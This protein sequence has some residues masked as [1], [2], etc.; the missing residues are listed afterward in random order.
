VFTWERLISNA[1]HL[2]HLD[3]IRGKVL[4]F[5]MLATLIPSLTL[6]WQ[7]YGLNKRFITEKI[8]EEVRN[9]TFQVV[10]ELDLW[11]KE[12]LYEI[13]VFSS[14]YEVVENIDRMHTAGPTGRPDDA[15]ARLIQYLQSV[16][17]K[18]GDYEELLVI[19]PSGDVL[20]TSAGQPDAS[21]LPPDWLRQATADSA[22]VGQIYL[23]AVRKRPALK[24]AVP[25][26]TPGGKL[27]GA[28][29]GTLNF[30]TIEKILGRIAFVEGGKAYL[31]REDGAVII[32][33]RPL[34]ALFPQ[35]RLSADAVRG[36]F[37][38]EH[39]TLE[40]ADY[41]GQPVRGTLRRVPHFGWGAVAEV[42]RLEAYAQTNRMWTRT[43]FLVGA[44]LAGISGTAYLL[45]LTI[46]RP[47][48]RLTG[49]AARVSAGDLD[50]QVPVV[51][52]SEVG[53]LT[54]VFNHMVIRLREGRDALAARNRA[55]QE[56]SIT[57]GLTGLYNHKHLL[58]TLDAE[59]ARARRLQHQF[60]VLMLDL[61]HFKRYND[62]Y[63][64]QAGDALLARVSTLFKDSIRSIDYAARYG[65]EEFLLLLHE[66]GLEGALRAAERI[67][68]RVAAERIGPEDQPVQITVSVGVAEFPG[69]GEAGPAVIA[70]ADAALYEAKRSGRNRVVRASG[71][72]VLP[73]HP[74]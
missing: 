17:A 72:V 42:G 62:T 39:G 31:L 46:V 37:Q 65:G 33:S 21:N 70:A 55:L 4:V 36:L 60:S 40:Y 38:G 69:H 61:D 34:P 41:L 63:G 54:S 18:F 58:E 59:V 25:I 24:I 49:G 74:R 73:E 52:R 22:V 45:E 1:L 50:V 44:L 64:H 20:A 32:A 16:R 67:R 29:A 6:G 30:G 23:D 43:L 48:D 2:V 12:R 71:A 35:T 56:L 57:D 9:A 10:R 53:Y 19:A 28:M 26:R 8:S 7:S 11:L 47:L 15:R 66:V 27:L 51:D 3:R 5:A 14:S 13:R 68:E